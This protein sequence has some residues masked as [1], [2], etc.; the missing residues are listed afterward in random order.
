MLNCLYARAVFVAFAEWQKR[1]NTLI[2][3]E[4]PAIAIDCWFSFYG[5]RGGT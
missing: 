5:A 4:K 2:H 3:K 1:R